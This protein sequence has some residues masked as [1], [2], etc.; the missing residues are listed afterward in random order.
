MRGDIAQMRANVVQ[1]KGSALLSLDIFELEAI[2]ND[3]RV[4]WT[5]WILVSIFLVLEDLQIHDVLEEDL[6][7]HDVLEGR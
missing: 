5:E 4:G 1:N 6:Q 2:E 7:I 3:L